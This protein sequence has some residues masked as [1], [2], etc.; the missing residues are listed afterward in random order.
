MAEHAAP[1]AGGVLP[2]ARGTFYI[3]QSDQPHDKKHKAGRCCKF[4]HGELRFNGAALGVELTAHVGTEHAEFFVQHFITA[5][6]VVEPVN[7]CGALCR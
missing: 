6:Y 5:V 3:N 7:L 1:F 4:S 2:G